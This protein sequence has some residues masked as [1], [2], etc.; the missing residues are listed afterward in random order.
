VLGEGGRLVSTLEMPDAHHPQARGKTGTRFT[1]RPDGQELTAIAGLVEAGE[2]RVFIEQ[3]FELE[4]AAKAL[5][6][7][8]NGHVH[9]KVVLRI[10]QR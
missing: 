9:G 7:V 8:A 10:Q 2:V 6:A 4:E 3:T 1:A 5:D